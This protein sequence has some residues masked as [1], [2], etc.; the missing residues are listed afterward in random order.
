MGAGPASGSVGGARRGD[1]GKSSSAGLRRGSNAADGGGDLKLRRGDKEEWALNGKHIT[2]GRHLSSDVKLPEDP[3]ASRNHAVISDCVVRDTQSSNGTFVNEVK[4]G[5]SDR[6]RLTHGDKL[7]VGTTTLDVESGSPPDEILSRTKEFPG[8][9]AAEVEKKLNDRRRVEKM[10][11]EEL[12][13]E[14]FAK[15]I[16]HE[17]VKKQLRRF[18]KKV[19]LDRIRE[20][21]QR[22]KERVGLYHMIFSGP[23]GTG[24]T[25]MAN[26]V[27]KVMLKMGLV[28]SQKTVFVNNSLELLAG[29]AGQTPGKVDAK[30]AEAK[31]GVLFIDEAYSIVKSESG[32]QRDSFGK[33]AIETIMKHLDPPSCV[34][35]FAGYTE[36]M[37]EFLRVNDGLSRR[38]PFRYTFQAYTVSELCEICKVMCQ[39]KGEVLD[40]EVV[41]ALPALIGGLDADARAS[42][43][44]G[45]ISNFLSFAQ[46]QRDKRIGKGL[47]GS[48]RA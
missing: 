3:E 16:G 36:P 35:I 28:K 10:T 11:V 27:T 7:R 6:V 31:G 12:M 39:S 8:L 48:L 25:S 42:Q 40:E 14:E 22:L 37:N 34:F 21:N 26:L 23:P 4:L 38:I 41:A 43:N 20:E 19:Q 47:D 24:K 18:N 13:D 46:I 45:L 2:I 32:S 29:F 33:E 30:V 44:A 5:P 17:D 1:E 9:S 15:I